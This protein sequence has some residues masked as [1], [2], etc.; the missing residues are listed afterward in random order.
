[1]RSHSQ[2]QVLI[3]GAGPAGLGAAEH[4]EGR[5]A[6]WLALERRSG[7]GGLSASFR[8][9][10]FTWDIGGH[11]IFSHY[12]EYDRLL[13]EVI[14]PDEWLWHERVA[15]VRICDRWVPYPLQ[16]NIWMLPQEQMWRCLRG[17]IRLYTERVAPDTSDFQAFINTHFGEGIAALFMDPYNFKTW[18]Y[19]PSRLSAGWIAERV[20]V[21]DLERVVRNAL[22]RREDA[23]WG[24]NNA[25]RYP[26]EGGTGEPW[27]RL[28][29]R[30]PEE[31]LWLDAHVVEVRSRDR[32]VVLSDGRT[33]HYEDL[34]S[35]MPLDN[36]I[37]VSDMDNL[38]EA[39]RG[40]MH[41]G[42]HVVGLGMRGRPPEAIQDFCWMYFPEANCPFYR[43]TLLSNYSPANAPSGHWSL[44]LETSESPEKL[45]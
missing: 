35:T 9:E 2:C 43:A 32:M 27:R 18:G 14:P 24:P 34:I 42:V 5:G 39:G 38:L 13:D 31:R 45:V 6:D 41:S 37:A 8:R 19:R 22:Q 40:L 44:L 16:N 23:S 3:I 25:F 17:V 4:L 20:A 7:V 15:Y 30:L 28:A 36:L 12:P 10:G 29:Q 33:I 26:A 21:V 11:V 1:M